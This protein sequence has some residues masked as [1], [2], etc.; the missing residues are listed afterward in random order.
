MQQ[1]Y[2][3]DQH[4][5]FA[6]I[7]EKREANTFGPIHCQMQ[8]TVKDVQ[9][10]E[11]RCTGTQKV[12]Q[13]AIQAYSFVDANGQKWTGVQLYD[14]EIEN[15]AHAPSFVA[16]VNHLNSLRLHQYR[17][18][19]KVYRDAGTLLAAL[20]VEAEDRTSRQDKF[21]AKKISVVGDGVMRDVVEC[22]YRIDVQ[23][24]ERTRIKPAKW[25]GGP[26]DQVSVNT[27]ITYD[28]VVSHRSLTR[29]N[30]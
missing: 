7:T 19:R 1:R 25:D 6:H 15:R 26:A 30:V 11:L 24:A 20:H 13:G 21:G 5:L 14:P 4:Y 16:Q 12:K 17:R 8:T 18:W 27:F 9:L 3:K 29:S 2:V 23:R 22:G 28:V 10:I